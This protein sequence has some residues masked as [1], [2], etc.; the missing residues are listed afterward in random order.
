MYFSSPLLTETLDWRRESARLS[1]RA[2]RA[3]LIAVTTAEPKLST[4]SPPS[5]YCQ[6]LQRPS[7][8]AQTLL[9]PSAEAL[10]S[11][12]ARA[13]ESGSSRPL[14]HADVLTENLDEFVAQDHVL[15]SEVQSSSE[16]G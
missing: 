6:G 2:S 4:Q 5:A 14:E 7:E 12:F 16:F 1:R 8:K 10:Q 11:V 9:L 13:S 15:A 3:S